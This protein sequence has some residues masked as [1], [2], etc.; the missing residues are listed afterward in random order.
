MLDRIGSRWTTLI[1]GALSGRSRRFSE[2]RRDVAGISEKMLAQT[3]RQLERDGL[4]RRTQHPVVPP[5]VEYDLTAMG[6]G[7][8]QLHQQLR[9]WAEDNFHDIRD[10]QT[11]YDLAHRARSPDPSG[12]T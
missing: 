6:V 11:S 2:L 8:E 10:S 4:V 7:M 9:M 5:R 3:L 1:T 12:T